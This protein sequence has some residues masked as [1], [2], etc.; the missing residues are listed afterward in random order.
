[1]KNEVG[2]EVAES[3]DAEGDGVG[4][5]VSGENTEGGR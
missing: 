2:G 4:A 1:M 3:V 5:A